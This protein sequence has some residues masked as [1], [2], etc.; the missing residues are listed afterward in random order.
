MTRLH[1]KSTWERKPKAPNYI[2]S[3]E[4]TY[5]QLYHRQWVR[6]LCPMFKDL[7]GSIWQVEPAFEEYFPMGGNY[8]QPIVYG[9]FDI[10]SGYML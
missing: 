5:I 4:Q 1:V 3:P 9:D 8:P 10:V 6:Q 7:A 2:A